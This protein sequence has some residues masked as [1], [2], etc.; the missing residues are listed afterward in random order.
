MHGVDGFIYPNEVELPMEHPHRALPVSD[1]TGGRRIHP[2]LAERV[3]NVAAVR[4]TYRLALLTALRFSSSRA[5][6]QMHRP[7]RALVRDV[8]HATH[9]VGDGNVRLRLSVAPWRCSCSRSGSTT[10]RISSARGKPAGDQAGVLRR[11]DALVGQRQSRGAPP[12]RPPW[13]HHHHR[14]HPIG[15][16]ASRLRRLHFRIGQSESVVVDATDAGRLPAFGHRLGR[17]CR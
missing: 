9:L 10:A 8:H 5:A 14:R 2:G 11:A 6:L 17:G 4:P 16:P 7:S 3:F 12:G 15:L 1:G 13:A